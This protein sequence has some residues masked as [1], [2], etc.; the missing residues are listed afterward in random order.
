MDWMNV[1]HL[2]KHYGNTDVARVG[3]NHP[4]IAPYGLYSTKDG[5]KILIGI[6]NEREFKIFCSEI[7]EMEW[8]ATKPEFDNNINR[9]ANRNALDKIINSRFAEIEL[10]MLADAL[11]KNNIAFG[12]LN[13]LDD[14]LVHSQTEFISVSSGGKE[15][16]LFSPS[17]IIQGQK[18]QLGEVPEL[19]Q[20]G[21]ELRIE[22]NI[23]KSEGY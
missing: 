16:N 8:L 19:D 23:I 11:Q 14:L 17:G 9:V 3:M 15:Y 10:D 13:G 1:P 18:Y 5:K 22:F 20:H 21:S 7:L 12:R 4:T 2:Q 6:Q